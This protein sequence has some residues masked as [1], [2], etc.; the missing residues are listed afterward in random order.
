MILKDTQEIMNTKAVTL[1]PMIMLV[2][3]TNTRILQEATLWNYTAHIQKIIAEVIPEFM[4]MNQHLGIKEIPVK[5]PQG[6]MLT[7]TLKFYVRTLIL[8]IQG[9]PKIGIVLCFLHAINCI[10][11]NVSFSTSY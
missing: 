9:Y 4:I 8:L 6:T 3:T 1:E 2:V 11:K 7:I 5:I 10:F